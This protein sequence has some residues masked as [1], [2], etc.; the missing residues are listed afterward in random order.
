MIESSERL[1][2]VGAQFIY[3]AIIKV[4]SLRVRRSRSLWENSGPRNRETVGLDA[5]R[6]HQLHVLFIAVVVIV[7]H[8]AC[9]VVDHLA[10]RVRESVPDGRAAPIFIDRALDLIG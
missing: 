9:R 4:Q 2:V 1:Y 10:G 5:Q 3:E 7:G 6:L 8:V